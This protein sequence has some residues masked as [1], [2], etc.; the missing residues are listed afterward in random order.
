MPRGFSGQRVKHFFERTN[1]AMKIAKEAHNKR[2]F[3]DMSKE[4]TR[5]P[6]GLHTYGKAIQGTSGYM[7][8]ESMV[9]AIRGM[10][11]TEKQESTRRINLPTLPEPRNHELPFSPEDAN[12]FNDRH[13][14]GVGNRTNIVVEQVIY[15]D[16][17]KKIEMTDDKAGEEIYKMCC[18][19]EEMCNTIYIVPET[20]PRVMEITG[21]L[22]DSMPQFRY[23]T[24]EVNI[25]T[26]K[27]FN[28]IGHIDQA[29]DG[30]KVVVSD[31]GAEHV[32]SSTKD[33]VG[34]QIRS[35]EDTANS[36]AKGA[37][38]LRNQAASFRRQ[39]DR[40]KDQIDMLEDRLKMLQERE[41]MERAAGAGNPLGVVNIATN[42]FRT[43][44]S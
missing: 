32:I 15:E 33:A 22:K 20:I 34:K 39:A 8:Q 11:E 29:S 12:P 14:V 16:A 6:R 38:S 3:E 31:E 2:P 21:R 18:K 41:A 19:I 4:V 13:K 5:P 25:Q 24:E 28:E 40:T 23:L 36:Y 1:D 17:I 7:P 9:N 42:P 35:M 37:E 27:F 26:R 44:R 10:Q 43:G 30:F